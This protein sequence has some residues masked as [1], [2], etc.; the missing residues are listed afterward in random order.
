MQDI[1]FRKCVYDIVT[2]TLSTGERSCLDRCAYKFKEALQFGEHSLKYI[3]Y[4]IIDTN[5]AFEDKL[6][7]KPN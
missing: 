2:P 5:T 6:A 7:V 4:K 3:N 1:C